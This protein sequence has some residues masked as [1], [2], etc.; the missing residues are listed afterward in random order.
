MSRII[1]II[2]IVRSTNGYNIAIR[3]ERDTEYASSLK[4]E[5][6]IPLRRHCIWLGLWLVEGDWLTDGLDEG[7]TDGLDE[8]DWLTDGL[9]D[10]LWLTDGLDESDGLTDG[11]WLVV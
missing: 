8:G 5:S 11:L 1:T 9:T 4:S 10:G 3:R 2:I 6:A 7:L